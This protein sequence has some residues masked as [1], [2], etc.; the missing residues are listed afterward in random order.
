MPR[1]YKSSAG[2]RLVKERYRAFLQRWPAAHQQLRVLTGQGETFVVASGAEGA[3]PLVLLHGGAANSAM[4]MGNIG[5]LARHFRVYAVDLIGE[6][7]LSAASRPP[8]ASDAH[9][10]WLDDVLAALS[11]DRACFAG[12]SLGGWLALDYATRRPERVERLA[13]LC[14][15]GVGRQKVGIVF[16][17]IF[18][19]MCGA[20]GKRKLLELILGRPPAD[21]APAAKAFI[22]FVLLIH[23]HFRPRMVK[24]PIFSDEALRRLNMPLLA[25][26]GGRD[27][28]LDS[29]E[30]RCRLERNAPQA[31]V[32][33]LAGPGHLLPDQTR[34]ILAFLAPGLKGAG[35]ATN[36]R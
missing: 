34:Q 3:S 32:V 4:W 17:T 10:L 9:A 25:V 33:Y 28:L 8:L 7:G 11:I 31:E 20:W 29:A 18:L 2:E 30:T 35:F 6:P 36:N 22:D 26:V 23:R 5:A 16:A 1:I 24:L 15:G 19:K 27:V 13:L 12:V 14:P 21:P